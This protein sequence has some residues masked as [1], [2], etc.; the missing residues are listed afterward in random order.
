M[1]SAQPQRRT[2]PTNELAKERNRAAAERTLNAWIGNCLALIGFGV[3][4]DQ[5]FEA[6]NQRFP[7]GNPI[8]TET[9]AHMIGLL[10]IAV[11]IFLLIMALLQHRIALKS[12]EQEDYV[13]LSVTAMNRVVVGAVVL[14]GCLAVFGILTLL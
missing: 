11:G 8:I 13:M 1:S 4:F 5:I 7:N 3:A 14:F 2:G 12:V 10:F 6:L 9:L